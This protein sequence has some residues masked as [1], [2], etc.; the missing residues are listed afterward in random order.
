MVSEAEQHHFLFQ[1]LGKDTN[2]HGDTLV[3]TAEVIKL[4]DPSLLYLEV[5]TL[6]RKYQ[7]SGVNTSACHWPSQLGHEANHQQDSRMA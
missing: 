2:R 3:T 7:T 4:T 1:K 5:W 6:V